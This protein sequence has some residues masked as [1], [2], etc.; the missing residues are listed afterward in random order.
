MSAYKA[1]SDSQ[2]EGTAVMVLP[3]PSSSL[4]RVYAAVAKVLRAKGKSVKLYSVSF[5]TI[6]L[7]DDML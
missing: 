6:R 7:T 1:F 5:P 2:P 4:R 3:S